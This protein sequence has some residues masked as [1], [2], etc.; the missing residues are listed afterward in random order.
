VRPAGGPNTAALA[1]RPELEELHQLSLLA[2]GRCRACAER[3]P[4]GAALSGRPC[5]RCGAPT[6]RTGAD[7]ALVAKRFGTSATR[8]MWIAVTL[9]GASTLVGGSL[10]LVAP[11]LVAVALSWVFGA[12]V[13]PATRLFSIRRRIAARWTVRLFTAAS[14]ALLFVAMEVLTLVPAVGAVVKAG[15]AAAQVAI[16]AGFARRYLSWQARR[17]AGGLPVTAGEW[18]VVGVAAA[19]VLAAMAAAF[20]A[21]AWALAKVEGLRRLLS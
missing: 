15:L 6:A 18:L 12:I 9:V 11:L 4:A 2:A 3:L 17:E 21:G 1:R 14:F 7:R 20:T 16:A 10:P 8:H 19:L 5:P 13:R